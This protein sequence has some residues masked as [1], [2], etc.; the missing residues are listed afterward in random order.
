MAKRKYTDLEPR[1]PKYM[2]LS[3]FRIFSK[4][5]ENY[6]ITERCICGNKELTRL[7]PKVSIPRKRASNQKWRKFFRDQFWLIGL[8]DGLGKVYYKRFKEM[9]SNS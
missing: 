1:S 4:R 3:C 6:G 5:Y 7:D 8:G 2:C 9:R